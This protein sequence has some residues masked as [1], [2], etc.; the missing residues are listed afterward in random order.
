MEDLVGDVEFKG[1]KASER[2]SYIMAANQGAL[3]VDEFDE[4]PRQA[5]ED[6]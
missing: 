3:P 5:K 6:I 1:G 4:K 2:F